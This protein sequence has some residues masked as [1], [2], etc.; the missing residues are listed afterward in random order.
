MTRAYNELALTAFDRLGQLPPSFELHELKAHIYNNQTKYSEAAAE[1]RQA[2]QLLPADLQIKK[3]LALSLKFGQDYSSALALFQELLQQQPDSAEFNYF[4][5]DT[6]LDLQRSKEALPLLKRGY[7]EIQNPPP[8]TRR[9][10]AANSQSA[11]RRRP[12]R[13]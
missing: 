11:N 3:N 7:F 1:W 9:W 4:V 13:I 2:L 12:F 6:L 10:P 5:G 8:H